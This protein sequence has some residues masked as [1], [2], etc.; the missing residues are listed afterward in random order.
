MKITKNTVTVTV[1]KS[2]ALKTLTIF[3]GFAVKLKLCLLLFL[4]V[5]VLC[6]KLERHCSHATGP[7]IFD[8]SVTSTIYSVS[9]LCC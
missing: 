4:L 1:L 8:T 7:G 5:A 6:A 9:W 2:F 3:D